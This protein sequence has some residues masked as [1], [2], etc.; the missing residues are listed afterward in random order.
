MDEEEDVIF[1]D[2]IDHVTPD[3]G[4]RKRKRRASDAEGQSFRKMPATG[5]SPPRTRRNSTSEQGFSEAA[6]KSMFDGLESRLGDRID[7]M[8]GEIKKNQSD[9]SEVKKRMDQSESNLLDRMDIQRRELEAMIK[10]STSPV[11][12]NRLSA[13]NEESYWHFRRSLSMW[14]IQGEDA[15][16]G[17]RTFM[18]QKLKFTE[19]QVKDL[20]KILI[21]R[22]KE[23]VP[24]A[25]KEVFCTFETKE[26][27]DLVKAASRHLAG[28]GNSVGLR[29]HFP[30]FLVDTFRMF[31][32]IGYYLRSGDQNIRRAVK[33]DDGVM[34]L[35]MDVKLGE[36]WKRIRPAEARKTIEENPH[37]K[38]G[39]EEISSETL[40]ELLAKT[41]KKSP[42][43]GA[44]SEPMA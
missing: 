21:R 37:I 41:K 25:R 19:E 39:P 14:P 3:P 18:M 20:G 13:K 30:G 17:L 44:N 16:I 35:V 1:V 28:L 7:R 36:E 29:P 24:K 22:L 23:P 9:I 42:A 27:R 6:L 2:Y 10:N 8:G 31:E 33:F 12:A 34:D 43:T 4:S 26:T 40:S 5:R 32:S 11:S 38:N 15:S